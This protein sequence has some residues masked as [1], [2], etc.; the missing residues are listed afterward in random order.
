EGLD[1][2]TRIGGAGAVQP[3][4]IVVDWPDSVGSAL[5]FGALRGLRALSDSL[6]ADPRVREVRSLVDLRAGMSLLEYLL[7]YSD[8]AAVRARGAA[9]LDL[10]LSADRRATRLDVVLADTTSLLSAMDVVRRAR[11]LAAAPLPAW[12]RARI[13]VG[14]Y[15]AQHVDFQ[16]D[17][18]SRV[19]LLVGVVFGATALMLGVVFRSVLV[20]V[21]AILLNAL[22][23]G[24]T[25]ALLVLVFQRGGAAPDGSRVRGVR[26]RAGP[27][28]P[29]AR[30]RAGRG[31]AAR[32]HRHSP[33]AG[34]GGDAARGPVELVAGRAKTAMTIKRRLVVNAD[35]FGLSDGVNRAISEAHAAGTVS[36]ASLLV[37]APGF[38]DAVRRARAAPAL[39]VGLHFNLT[40]GAP[41]SPATAVPSL[42]D[43][44][45]GRFWSLSRLIARALSGRV[46]GA[47]VAL[48][49][50][51]QIARAKSSGV[52]L[53]HLD[54]HQ[55]THVLPGI[56]GP[57]SAA[58]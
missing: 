44:R 57:V 42:S 11:R 8:L 49:C 20:P 56:W 43:R 34:A 17:L 9:A 27:R 51:A 22:S 55:H 26:V 47:E 2:L 18:L 15:V 36:S 29:A 31:G 5:G 38:A 45:T 53:T 13:F 30:L 19:P 3:V 48:E 21:K 41:V 35:D 37:N 50:A 33:R 28:D 12:A 1:L 6:R 52:R 25:L 10:L 39:G 24:S 46:D 23:V 32:R 7:W 14:G 16:D 4:R 40:M 58:A 54:G